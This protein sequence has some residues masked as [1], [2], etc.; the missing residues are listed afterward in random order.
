MKFI[1]KIPLA[2]TGL[3]LGFI[4]GPSSLFAV[5]A[6]PPLAD[7]CKQSSIIVLGEYVGG[8]VDKPQGCQFWVTFQIK[9]EKYYKKTGDVAELKV[10]QFKKRYFVDTPQC[11]NIPGP[12]AMPGDMTEKLKKPTHEKK[13]F[14]FKEAKENLV[15]M[16]NVFWGIIDWDQAKREWHKEFETTKECHSQ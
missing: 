7:L 2:L 8:M 12:N 1:R 5:P 15:E 16:S 9:P 10:L 4:A 13:L 11:S 3:V 6:P 14:F